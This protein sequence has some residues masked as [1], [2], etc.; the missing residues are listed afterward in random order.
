ILRVVR[1]RRK[2]RNP[3]R[4][5]G[6]AIQRGAWGLYYRARRTVRTRVWCRAPAG[7]ASVLQPPRGRSSA[8]G[9]FALSDRPLIRWVKGDG[10][11]DEVTRSAIAQATRLFGDAVDY[12]LTVNNID[13]ARAR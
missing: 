2:L 10:L 6:G 13:M 9:R 5:A 4:F 8:D 11:D 1:A 12:C 3:A 7:H